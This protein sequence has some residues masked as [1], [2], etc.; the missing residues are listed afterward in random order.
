MQVDPSGT[1]FGWKAS[2]IGKDFI[3][4]KSIL[5]KVSIFLQNWHSTFESTHPG[6]Q[7]ALQRYDEEGELEDAIH[8][9]LLTL[10]ESIE[11]E[12]N[13]NNIEIGIIGEDR[14]FRVLTPAEIKDYLEEAD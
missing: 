6:S 1:F 7:C 8:T 10:K 9:A 13:E 5:E 14:V 3:N 11:G 4:A 12:M 2:A